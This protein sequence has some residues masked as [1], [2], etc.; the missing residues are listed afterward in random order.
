MKVRTV[1]TFSIVSLLFVILVQVAGMI[2]AYHTQMKEVEKSLNDCFEIAFMETVDN[3]VNKLDYPDGTVIGYIYAPRRL[4]RSI[5]EFFF[6]GSEQVASQLRKVY[7]VK[8][9]SLSALDS[10]LQN[11]LKHLYI[12]GK[13]VI[14]RLNVHTG[15]VLERTQPDARFPFGS[16]S[17]RTAFIYKEEG[18]AV[19][20]IVIFPQGEI[21]RNVLI[22]FGIT[23][24]FLLITVYALVVQV[25]SVLRQQSSIREQQ[26]GFY[27]LAEQM[28]IPVTGM[29]SELAKKTWNGIEKE[30]NLL[31]GM[32]EE[33]L[34]KAKSEARKDQLRKVFSSKTA[35]IISMAGVFLLL[36]IWSSYLYRIAYKKMELKVQDHFV[37]AFYQETAY[38]RQIS[39]MAVNHLHSSQVSA[40]RS[41]TP[42]AAKQRE[43]LLRTGI[44]LT[45]NATLVY[46]IYNEI[47]E[48]Y[49]LRA[50]YKMQDAVNTSEIPIAFS[51]QYADTA[52][53]HR[54]QNVGIPCRS[55]VF[56]MKYPSKERLLYTGRPWIGKRDM[57]TTLIPLDKDS[58]TCIQ[59]V[60]RTPQQFILSSIWYMMLPLVITFL[61]MWICVFF[62]IRMLRMQRRLKQFQKDFSYSMIHDMKSPLSSI[63]MGA[64]I[65]KSGKLAD[66]PEKA[67][68]YKRV[69]AEECEHLLTLSSRVLMLTQ[70]EKGELQLEREEVALEPLLQDLIEKF[71]LKASKAVIFELSCNSLSVDADPFCLREVLSNVIDNALK[72]SGES[73]KVELICEKQ[74]EWIVIRIKD[75]GIGI[76]QKD[77]Q[78]IFEKFERVKGSSQRTG[79]SG[80]GLG[81][82]YVMR[83]VQAHGGTIHVESIEG[84]YSEFTLL[85]PDK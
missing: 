5:N 9:F 55:D 62:Q 60:I 57:T 75:N 50:A 27:A 19:Q 73:V 36:V 41:L 49:Q 38:H 74:E 78:K 25:K 16:V 64:S 84:K 2:Y 81:L 29:I 70:I 24:L 67:D 54:I 72:Y 32:T 83:V 11:K 6:H 71:R 85:L 12:E 58:T 47:N 37:D 63:I 77:R 40:A 20:A 18:E 17:S 48:N 31:L 66:K 80:F 3:I 46:H 52:F 61:F 34:N 26:Q 13:V 7:K 39:Y 28:R 76:P 21:M 10:V 4:N 82:N 1:V 69:M 23:L 35:S 30:S 42:F 14:Q 43:Y 56:W 15:E 8:E 51:L 79:A 33:V 59:G 68:K 22:L 65:L 45:A 53:A 44:N